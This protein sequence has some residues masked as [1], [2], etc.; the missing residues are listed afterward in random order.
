MS[1]KFFKGLCAPLGT[2]EMFKLGTEMF[3]MRTFQGFDSHDLCDIG[4][5]YKLSF[6]HMDVY[7]TRETKF[8]VPSQLLSF[9]CFIPN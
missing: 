5:S 7:V 4:S 1:E 6:L 3:H 2:N 8:Y 9:F